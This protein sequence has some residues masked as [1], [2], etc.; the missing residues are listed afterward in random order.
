MPLDDEADKEGTPVQEAPPGSAEPWWKPILEWRPKPSDMKR[1]M[2]YAIA[3]DLVLLAAFA[4]RGYATKKAKPEPPIAT[5]QVPMSLSENIV[6]WQAQSMP[7]LD[8]L[9]PEIQSQLNPQRV[10]NRHYAG[11]D[12]ARLEFF[13]TA[14]NGR[15]TFHDPHNCSLGSDAQLQDVGVV[16]IQTSQGTLNVLEARYKRSGSPDVFEMMFCY[17]AEG[18]VLQRTEQMHKALVW[19]TFFG[20]AGKPSY[21]LRFTQDA[22]GTE[23]EKRAQLRRFIGAMWEQIGPVLMGKVKAIP[24]PPPVPLALPGE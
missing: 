12:G 19:Q 10:I 21:F 11:T 8:K 1:L 7:D 23:D 20:D 17:V 15:W 3:L 5:F 9:T 13:L 18:K 4:A 6:N 14:G 22:A 16:P 2:P 24:Q